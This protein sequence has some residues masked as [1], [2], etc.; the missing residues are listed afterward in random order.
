MLLASFLVDLGIV[1][2]V[3][4]NKRSTFTNLLDLIRRQLELERQKIITEALLLARGGD[5]HNILI[6]TP[7]KRDLGR[8]DSVLLRQCCENTINR[9]SCKL[10][11]R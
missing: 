10:R 11:R 8:A 7:S 9:S 2:H 5:G 1:S 6:D 3:P 4:P